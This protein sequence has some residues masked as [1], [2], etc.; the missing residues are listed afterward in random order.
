MPAQAVVQ[1]AWEVLQHTGWDH[2]AWREA[3]T[4]AQLCLA[5]AYV[6]LDS[7][8]PFT[9]AL[10]ASSPNSAQT[11]GL[12]KDRSMG[13]EDQ[14]HAQQAQS[15]A[16]VTEI[17]HCPAMKALQALDL[18]SIMGAPPDLLGPV[19]DITEPLAHQA[20]QATFAQQEA[21][22]SHEA[23]PLQPCQPFCHQQAEFQ[24]HG[25]SPDHCQAAEQNLGDCKGASLAS[26]SA[27]LPP[28]VPQ[29]DPDRTIPRR[30]AVGVTAAEFRKLYWKTD[31]PVVITGDC[32][33]ALHIV[34]ESLVSHHSCC[35]TEPK[36]PSSYA[37]VRTKEWKQSQA[38]QTAD[39][40]YTCATY[41]TNHCTGTALYELC[42]PLACY[43][44]LMIAVR[45]T[46]FRLAV[47]VCLGENSVQHFMTDCEHPA[48][49]THQQCTGVVNQACHQ[50]LWHD[51]ATPRFSKQ[52]C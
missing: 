24:N 7:S 49:N 27:A 39:V 44:C 33:V 9:V 18:A 20:Y 47:I 15:A 12:A 37:A 41:R 10:E 36:T 32:H 28:K 5:A 19:L 34:P 29:L 4:L 3:Y 42:S 2:P 30:Q 16:N 6:S 51:K 43:V 11:N 45:M 25:A 17:L 52:P 21:T 13:T 26:T 46:H 38:R 23:V 31:T 40:F 1:V 35:R 22:C 48:H 8:H 50:F 14:W